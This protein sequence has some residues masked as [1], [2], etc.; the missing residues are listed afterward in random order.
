MRLVQHERIEQRLREAETERLARELRAT[1]R[2]PRRW[3]IVSPLRAAPRA[4]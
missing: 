2:R 3:Q 4:N 1:D